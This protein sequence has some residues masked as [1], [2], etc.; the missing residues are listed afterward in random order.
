MKWLNSNKLYLMDKVDMN[1]Y[2][3]SWWRRVH[4]CP[5]SLSE[6][7]KILTTTQSGYSKKLFQDNLSLQTNLFPNPESC[8][9]S[10]DFWRQRG[11][12]NRVHNCGSSG[13]SANTTKKSNQVQNCCE[14]TKIVKK[15]S[16]T[17]WGFCALQEESHVIFLLFIYCGWHLWWTDQ[18]QSSQAC[19]ILETP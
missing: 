4:W 9:S 6:S 13:G 12:S 11:R 10:W 17:Y 7:W 16:T 2:S 19:S 15:C 3:E 8:P 18:A 1:Y 14:A 5:R